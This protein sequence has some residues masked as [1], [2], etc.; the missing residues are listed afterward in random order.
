VIPGARRKCRG[1]SACLPASGD[2][3]AGPRWG[4]VFCCNLYRGNGV[5]CRVCSV[6]TPGASLQQA[7]E[8]NH[9]AAMGIFKRVNEECCVANR[10]GIAGRVFQ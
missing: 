2:A 1:F 8:T 3:L 6:D 4:D 5:V 10:T 9:K 7:M